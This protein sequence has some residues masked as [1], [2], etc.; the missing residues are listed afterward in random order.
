VLGIATRWGLAEAVIASVAGMLC[1]N[2][3]FLPPVGTLT[4]SDPQN[5][6]ALIVFLVTAVIASHLSSSAKERAEE[7]IL[8]QQ[9]MERL[10]ALSR[11]L[12]LV[13]RHTE[14]AKQ[15]AKQVAQVFESSGVAFFDR[16]SDRIY[17]AGLK[18]SGSTTLN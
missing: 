9:E 16:G 10:Y 2:Y 14:L 12:L 13:D 5:W 6:V 11:S 18:M 7:A 17:R 1:F 8:R 3:F 4:I 15:V